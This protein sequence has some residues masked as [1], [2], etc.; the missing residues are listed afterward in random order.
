MSPTPEMSDFLTA[1][2]MPFDLHI[3]EFADSNH[4][5]LLDRFGIKPCQI[6]LEDVLKWGPLKTKA[7]DEYSHSTCIS[8]PVSPCPKLL[9]EEQITLD[10]FDVDVDV[11]GKTPNTNN[12]QSDS[13]ADNPDRDRF[14]DRNH[15]SHT[16]AD[17]DADPESPKSSNLNTFSFPTCSSSLTTCTC[18]YACM[19]DANADAAPASVSNEQQYDRIGMMSLCLSGSGNL[20]PFPLKEPENRTQGPVQANC[21]FEHAQLGH[22]IDL[23]DTAWLETPAIHSHRSFTS[24]A[25]L[26]CTHSGC[27]YSPGGL[28]RF[29][30]ERE[31]D[32]HLRSH[33]CSTTATESATAAPAPALFECA[34]CSGTFS[35]WQRLRVHLLSHE[36]RVGVFFSTALALAVHSW[37][38][39]EHFYNGICNLFT[40]IRTPI[41]IQV[42]A[43]PVIFTLRLLF[44]LHL[45]ILV[46]LIAFTRHLHV[47]LLVLCLHVQ[48]QAAFTLL[49]LH[50]LLHVVFS[51]HSRP[52]PLSLTLIFILDQYRIVIRRSPRAHPTFILYPLPLIISSRPQALFDQHPIVF[53]PRQLQK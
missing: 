24:Q 23:L 16:N 34:E 38:T 46:P 32:V 51:P 7:S 18:A 26:P 10:P 17:P 12:K 20:H 5:F 36:V 43:T 2:S 19:L 47:L 8:N 41:P 33:V 42:A 44:T 28:G 1:E 37:R 11:L 49:L 31:R 52:H 22:I 14:L 39:T 29:S 45:L 15:F 30:N 35:T 3:P 53:S 48:L 50:P 27:L 4:R 6:T 13:I 21:E 25:P 40:P 9:L